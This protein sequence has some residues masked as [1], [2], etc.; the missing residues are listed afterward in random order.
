MKYLFFYLE[1]ATQEHS[2]SKICE[3]GYVITNEKFEV[4]ERGNFIF[5]LNIRDSEWNFNCF[6]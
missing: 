5:N 3:F 1:F 6:K 2:K 4:L